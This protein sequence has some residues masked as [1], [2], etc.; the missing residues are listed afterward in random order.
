MDFEPLTEEQIEKERNQPLEAGIYDFDCI[1]CVQKESSK[2]DPMFAIKIKVYGRDRN[3]NVYDY[4]L[5]SGKMAFKLKHFCDA[6][7]LVKQYEKGS[8]HEFDLLNKSGKVEIVI[9]AGNEQYP[10]PKNSVRDYH[11]GMES[12]GLEPIPAQNFDNDSIPF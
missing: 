11:V 7:G 1:E 8:L 9:Q 6:T 5:A 12:K 4:L 10:N 2:G 3:Q